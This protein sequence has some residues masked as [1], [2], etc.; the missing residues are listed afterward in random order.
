MFLY[1]VLEMAV[2]NTERW[3]CYIEMFR[4]DAKAFPE[5]STARRMLLL[6]DNL[7]ASGDLSYLWPSVSMRRW[8]LISKSEAW[9]HEARMFSIEAF[10]DG[11]FGIQCFKKVAQPS[12]GE[13]RRTLDQ[14]IETFWQ[15]AKLL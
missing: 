14:T 6:I 11:T 8:L 2:T 13:M 9:N 10:D 4:E 7:R 1:G 12:G 3:N 5:T 15:L